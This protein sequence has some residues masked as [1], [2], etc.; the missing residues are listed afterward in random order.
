M[1][2]NGNHED[3]AFFG[4][5]LVEEDVFGLMLYVP[6]S[7]HPLFLSYFTSCVCDRAR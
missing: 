7:L 5:Y 3:K 2:I 1:T 6:L 4:E